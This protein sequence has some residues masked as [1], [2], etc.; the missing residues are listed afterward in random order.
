MQAGNKTDST[1]ITSCSLAASLLSSSLSRRACGERARL[2]ASLTSAELGVFARGCFSSRWMKTRKRACTCV[3]GEH[4]HTKTSSSLPLTPSPFLPLPLQKESR[5]GKL[6]LSP[7]ILPLT[8]AVLGLFARPPT[9]TRAALAPPPPGQGLDG[10]AP[11][12]PHCPRWKAPVNHA[13]VQ[14]TNATSTEGAVRQSNGCM[15]AVCEYQPY[16]SFDAKRL[17]RYRCS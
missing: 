4:K 16:Q 6:P 11:P 2:R 10:D 17:T 12:T 15:R 8:C 7:P 1:S 14:K 9:P 13:K 3:R 5:P